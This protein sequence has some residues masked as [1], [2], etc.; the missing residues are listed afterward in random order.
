METMGNQ[1]SG[2]KVW[3]IVMSVILTAII[4]GGGV[5][6]WQTNEDKVEEKE[7]LNTEDTINQE[8]VVTMG[9]E[10]VALQDM[11]LISDCSAIEH[12]IPTKE[13]QK[14]LG[15]SSLLDN[16]YEMADV[17]KGADRISFILA[18]NEPNLLLKDANQCLSACDRAAFGTI[19]TTKKEMV[20]VLSAHRLGIYSEAYNQFC[21][22][23]S[24]QANGLFGDTLNFYCGSG[25]SGGFTTWSTYVFGDDGLTEVQRLTEMGPPEV[26]EAEVADLL[27]KFHFKSNAEMNAI[28]R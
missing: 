23:D 18:K 9:V 15:I 19:D 21:R 7:I 2:G 5:Y 24:I 12:K 1:S 11:Q 6:F 28:Q 14:Q 17:C 27:A 13:I 26:F 4:V 8:K 25:E 16:G 10:D 20:V 22:I 3:S